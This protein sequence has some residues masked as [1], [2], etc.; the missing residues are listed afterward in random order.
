VRKPFTNEAEF[1]WGTLDAVIRIAVRF[2]DGVIDVT[3][4]PMLAQKKEE[5]NKRRLG[6]GVAGLADAMAFLGHQYGSTDSVRFARAVMKEIALTAYGTS[7]DLAEEKGSFPLFDQAQYF[8][9]FAG[10]ALPPQMID[11]IHNNGIRNGVLMTVAPTGTTSILFGNLAG[12]IEPTF[13]HK[14]QRKVL[15][16]DGKYK[17]FVSYGYSARVWADVM[18]QGVPYADHMVTTEDLTVGEHLAV[19]AACQEWVDASVSKTINCGEDISFDEFQDVYRLAYSKG[20]KGCTTYRPTEELGSV[21]S[22]PDVDRKPKRP[23][24]LPGRTYKLNWPSWASAIYITINEK[25]DKIY[26][27][28]ISSKDARY[29]EWTI[30]LSTMISRLLRKDESPKVIAGELEQIQSTHDSAW[31]GKKRYGSLL[32]RIGEVII[33]HVASKDL[34]TEKLKQDG[35]PQ[36]VEICPKC[37]S[38]TLIRREGCRTC[39]TCGYSS[40][41]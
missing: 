2:L 25:D 6:L 39:N 33:Q 19:Q 15:Q 30:A 41:E 36:K 37:Q 9:G 1:D 28:F 23:D 32:A 5:L 4:Y 40:C 20:C 35:I 29:Q 7:C 34:P 11:R 3:R 13:R 17:E 21:L 31:V 10:T 24:V 27:L 38:P 26:E 14:A 22:D 8:S 12:G 16:A 18:G